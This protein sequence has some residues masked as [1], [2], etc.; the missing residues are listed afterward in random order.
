MS[1]VALLL[2]G[3]LLALLILAPR[4]PLAG[5]RPS[6]TPCGM[7]SVRFPAIGCTETER[8]LTAHLLSKRGP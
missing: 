6:I 4:R 5:I 3:P 8:L 2:L 1:R 7:T